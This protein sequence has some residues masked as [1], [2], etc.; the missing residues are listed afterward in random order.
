MMKGN[1]NK[2]NNNIDFAYKYAQAPGFTIGCMVGPVLFNILVFCLVFFFFIALFVFVLFPMII[3]YWLSL[4]FSPV[5]I[6]REVAQ[7]I[8]CADMKTMTGER[9]RTQRDM[10]RPSKSTHRILFY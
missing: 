4:R 3:H 8:C 6:K 5:Y 1:R 9:E 10:F 7:F 2:N